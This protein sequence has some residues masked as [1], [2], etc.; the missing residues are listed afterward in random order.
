MDFFIFSCRCFFCLTQSFCVEFE[1][2]RQKNI[3]KMFLLVF[4]FHGLI[5]FFKEN[6]NKPRM[7]ILLK[8]KYMHFFFLRCKI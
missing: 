8:R 2:L 4:Q 1:I 3:E 5:F 6:A 7:V